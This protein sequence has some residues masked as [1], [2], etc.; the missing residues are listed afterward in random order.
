M[1]NGC[2][3]VARMADS[4]LRLQSL[5]PSFPCFVQSLN[6]FSISRLASELKA[7]LKYRDF[8]PIGEGCRE[9]WILLWVLA[10]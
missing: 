2:W 4:L 7:T 5:Q 9:K 1:A 3:C 8:P 10:P 6:V